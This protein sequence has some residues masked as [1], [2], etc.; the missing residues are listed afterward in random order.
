MCNLISLFRLAGGILS[1]ATLGIGGYFYINNY[2]DLDCGNMKLAIALGLSSIILFLVNIITY[3]SSCNK[4][5]V[6][7]LCGLFLLGSTGYNIYIKENIDQQCK[8]NYENK[9]IWEYYIYMYVSMIVLSVIFVGLVI[10][11]SCFKKKNYGD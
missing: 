4:K 3:I 9:N 7:T 2:E 10:T 8:Q 1:L 5:W 6:I 11:S